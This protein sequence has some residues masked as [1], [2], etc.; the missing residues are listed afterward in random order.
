MNDN[1]IDFDELA[2]LLDGDEEE[3]EF[4]RGRR[5]TAL[6]RDQLLEVH[7][8]LRGSHSVRQFIVTSDFKKRLRRLCERWSNRNK[9]VLL[10]NS[11]TERFLGVLHQL[12]T[13]AGEV[14]YYG[15]PRDPDLIFNFEEHPS[16]EGESQHRRMMHFVTPDKE[17]V[18]EEVVDYAVEEKASEE[19][20]VMDQDAIL[21][22]V[23][24]LQARN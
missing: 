11:D 5:V 3:G 19:S 20:S 18:L 7:K 21:A 1:L 22:M 10:K 4:D 24:E 12:I 2:D 8:N 23:A 17:Y 16:P 14:E 9:P 15:E 6:E 13:N